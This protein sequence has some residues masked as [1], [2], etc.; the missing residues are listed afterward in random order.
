MKESDPI[1][2]VAD[3]HLSEEAITSNKNTRALKQISQERRIRYQQLAEGVTPD[4]LHDSIPEINEVEVNNSYSTKGSENLSEEGIQLVAWNTERGR[5]PE[6]YVKLIK[7]HPFLLSSPPAIIFLGEMD[8]GMARSYNLHTTKEMAERL[9][10]NYAYGVEFLELTKGDSRE[11]KEYE[12]ENEWGYHGNAILSKYPLEDVRLIRF[13]GI[14]KWYVHDQQRLGGRMALFAKVK[15]E[16][17]E[18]VLISTHLES[19]KEEVDESMR[20]A[21]M[22]ILLKE[23]DQ[24]APT[25]PALLGGDLNTT[26]ESDI[27]PA[28]AQAGFE[29]EQAND[30][31]SG[32][33]QDFKG[34]RVHF[35]NRH[36]DYLCVRGFDIIQHAQ[37]P[38]VIPAV[39]PPGD[40]RGKILGDHAIVNVRIQFPPINHKPK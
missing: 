31:T 4:M 10:M 8:L 17:H 12:G 19:G 13:P 36:I 20:V 32:T 6:E 16:G 27:F 30:L 11:K 37:S 35:S 14:E 21:M 2:P 5:Y 3:I 39:Y 7:E 23:L 40:L 9:E 1:Q 22:K 28:L 38:S 24:Y 29:V 33:S 15:I 34:N 18:I 25:L 26:M